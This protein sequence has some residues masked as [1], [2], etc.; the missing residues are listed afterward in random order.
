[1]NLAPSPWMLMFKFIQ[2]IRLQQINRFFEGAQ[3]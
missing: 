1:M 2:G 3:D